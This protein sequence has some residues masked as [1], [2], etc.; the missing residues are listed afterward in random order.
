[1]YDFLFHIIFHKP[2][3]SPAHERDSSVEV[4][5]QVALLWFDKL[6]DT[7]R[8]VFVAVIHPNISRAGIVRMH[9]VP[10]RVIALKSKVIAYT[11]RDQFE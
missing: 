4:L 7:T 6:H 5:S 11:G 8:S 1:M 10:L 3:H 9:K 2:F